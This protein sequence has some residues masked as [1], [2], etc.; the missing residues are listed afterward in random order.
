MGYYGKY[1]MSKKA[2]DIDLVKIE[3]I[4]FQGGTAQATLDHI[5]GGSNNGSMIGGTTGLELAFTNQMNLNSG[6]PQT[7]LGGSFVLSSG[8]MP[9]MSSSFIQSSG[10]LQ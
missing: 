1:S 5:H 2:V 7:Q 6:P 10:G 8:G 4:N 9:G 3:P